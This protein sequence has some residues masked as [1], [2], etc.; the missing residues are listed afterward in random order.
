MIM[1]AVTGENGSKRYSGP[2]DSCVLLIIG[3]YFG[4]PK[5]NGSYFKSADCYIDSNTEWMG[6]R[7]HDCTAG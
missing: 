4:I 5:K 3:N 1:I 7:I 6:R 2:R